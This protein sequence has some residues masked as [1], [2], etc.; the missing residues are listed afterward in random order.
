MDDVP[1]KPEAY[2]RAAA[3]VSALDRPIA[4]IHDEGGEAALQ[5]I[6]GVGRGIAARIA[7]LV[8]DGH[9][10]DLDAYRRRIPVDM[11]SLTALEGLGPKRVKALWQG[12]RIKT[13]DDL[14]AAVLS[15]RVR[16]LP[17]FG[18][19]SEKRLLEAVETYRQSTGRWPIGQVLGLARTV[20][21]RLRDAPDVEAASVAGS[22]RRLKTTVGDLDFL[23][24]TSA[25]EAVMD[26]FA[27]MPEVVQVYAKGPTKTMVRLEQ[28]IDADLRVVPREAYGAALLYFTGSKAHNIALRRIA[29]RRDLK[30]SE[31]GLFDGET[32]IAGRTEAEVYAALDLPWIPPELREGRGEIEAAA[33]GALPRLIEAEELRGDLQI[34]SSWTDGTGSVEDLA[35]AALRLGR[36]YIAITD[37]TRDL[38]MTGGLDERRLLEQA[39][40]VRAVDRK[41]KGIRILTGAE[42]NIRRDGSLD[43]SDAVLSKLDVVGAGIHSHFDMPRDEMTR[44]MIRAMENPHVDILFHPSSRRLGRR[45]AVDFDLEAILEAAR[46]TG[47]ALE[48]DAH[49]GRLDLKPDHVHEAVRRGVKLV[50]D[51][52]AHDFNEL[53]YPEEYGVGVARRGWAEA[54]DVLNTLPVEQLLAALK[55]GPRAGR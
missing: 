13:L 25:P 7:E 11:V 41:M 42:V 52:D 15:G 12:L 53:R 45:R 20:E 48:I 2:Q 36:D 29:M 28:G 24:V 3:S 10:K 55:D 22:L 18:A 26:L 23:A 27:S 4:A 49:P 51:S 30:L 34:Q 21:R 19:Q 33:A 17:R 1:F 54:K 39:R 46:R 50:I 14:E 43:V 38:A 16:A 32:P 44:R 35:A 31:Y 9:C 8:E 6:P 37:H 47:T 5:R 40:Y